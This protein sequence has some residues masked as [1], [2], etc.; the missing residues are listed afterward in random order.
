MVN[1]EE[2]GHG[3][4]YQKENK[5]TKRIKAISSSI[6]TAIQKTL[7]PPSVQAKSYSSTANNP[8]DADDTANNEQFTYRAPLQWRKAYVVRNFNCTQKEID[9]IYHLHRERSVSTSMT[10]SYSQHDVLHPSSP[11]KKS[12][13][14]S[15][16]TEKDMVEICTTDEIE[17]CG[18]ATPEGWILARFCN[19]HEHKGYI[20]VTFIQQTHV[21]KKSVSTRSGIGAALDNYKQQQ[22]ENGKYNVKKDSIDIQ[23]ANEDSNVPIVSAQTDDGMVE[24]V[25]ED[26]DRMEIT[27]SQQTLPFHW[28]FSSYPL[29]KRTRKGKIIETIVLSIL[30]MIYV[31]PILIEDP[32]PDDAPDAYYIW[33]IN[34]LL[35]FLPWAGI[36]ILRMLE[37][38]HK[39]LFA[40]DEENQN[41]KALYAMLLFYILILVYFLGLAAIVIESSIHAQWI[42]DNEPWLFLAT[43]VEI[44]VFIGCVI[45]I[46][47]LLLFVVIWTFC[48][49]MMG[50]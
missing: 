49:S 12:D 5:L 33:W 39:T 27:R 7:D 9:Q 44:F 48:C 28:P 32:R 30:T 17:V 31:L 42:R 24:E 35:V 43:I 16:K 26:H 14:K 34:F 3:S 40:K 1:D 37:I 13:L 22:L 15:R 38:W 50:N 2:L 11:S 8:L 29:R 21:Q 25:M 18:D 46:V 36:F 41:N 19:E 6:S 4:S 20:P 10:M 23:Y 45:I 47:L